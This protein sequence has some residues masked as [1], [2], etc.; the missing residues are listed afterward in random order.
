MFAIHSLVLKQFLNTTV[1]GF[2]FVD[3]IT[4][5]SIENHGPRISSVPDRYTIFIVTDV[6]HIPA[7]GFGVKSRRDDSL[8]RSRA[9]VASD[10]PRTYDHKTLLFPPQFPDCF[11]TEIINCP[12][13]RR[14]LYIYM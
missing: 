3:D 8:E 7:T 9:A 2:L 14:V 6:G 10:L 1:R 12:P 4:R 11:A 13:K 5:D